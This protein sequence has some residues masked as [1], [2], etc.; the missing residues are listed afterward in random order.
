MWLCAPP[1]PLVVVR[2]LPQLH[3]FSLWPLLRLARDMLC[4][5]VCCCAVL[6]CV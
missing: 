3:M 6:C 4:C 1:P 2:W 5:A